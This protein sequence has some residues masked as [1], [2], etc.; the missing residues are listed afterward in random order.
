MLPCGVMAVVG[1]AALVAKVQGVVPLSILSSLSEPF[2][3]HLQDLDL[4]QLL[5]FISHFSVLAGIHDSETI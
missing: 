2:V 1:K 4:C 3:Q 5:L